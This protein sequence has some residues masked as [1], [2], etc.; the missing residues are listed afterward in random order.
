MNIRLLHRT[1]KPQVYAVSGL[2]DLVR[3]LRMCITIGCRRWSD[4]T[5][6]PYPPTS[7][8]STICLLFKVDSHP[9]PADNLANTS[10]PGSTPISNK[11]FGRFEV[12]WELVCQFAF[13]IWCHFLSFLYLWFIND[14]KKWNIMSH[15]VTKVWYITLLWLTTN[16]TSV[17]FIPLF[18]IIYKFWIY[19]P[20]IDW[21]NIDS[22]DLAWYSLLLL[23]S[24]HYLPL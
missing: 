5:V 17:T 18:K 14:L 12:A 23:V 20:N 24:Y 22:P 6:Q 4:V 9:R 21:P 13:W 3:T 8:R 15:L 7:Y 16:H 19:K 10:N 2:T 1:S 11:T